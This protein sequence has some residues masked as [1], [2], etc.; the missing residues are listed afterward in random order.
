VPAAAAMIR[1]TTL[2]TIVSAQ[3][4]SETKLRMM[5]VFA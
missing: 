5:P 1:N 4:A 3:I 2:T